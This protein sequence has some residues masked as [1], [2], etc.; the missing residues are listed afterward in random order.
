MTVSEAFLI[1][2]DD[3]VSLYTL[4]SPYSFAGIQQLLQTCIY[5]LSW[6]VTLVQNYWIDSMFLVELLKIRKPKTVSDRQRQNSVF[7]E[8]LHVTK[9]CFITLSLW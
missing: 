9:M 6:A 8:T 7:A 3:I 5:R 1:V 4:A 2:V